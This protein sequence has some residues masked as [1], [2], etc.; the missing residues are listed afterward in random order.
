M[1]HHVVDAMLVQMMLELAVR[2]TYSAP[3]IV[4]VVQVPF[5]AV[6]ED[7]LAVPR[8]LVTMTEQLTVQ[9]DLTIFQTLLFSGTL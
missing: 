3:V 6:Q 2:D 1:S 5:P 9:P 8:A 7:E 4:R